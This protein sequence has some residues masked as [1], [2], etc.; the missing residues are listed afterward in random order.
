MTTLGKPVS[1]A[2]GDIWSNALDNARPEDLFSGERLSQWALENG[3]VEKPKPEPL[4]VLVRRWRTD[5]GERKW[6]IVASVETR[7]T[8]L[9][10]H[11]SI[12]LANVTPVAAVDDYDLYCK[13]LAEGEIYEGEIPE[14]LDVSWVTGEA[15]R[16]QLR[17]TGGV[18]KSAKYLRLLE[19]GD[20]AGYGI[21]YAD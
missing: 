14:G 12:I 5:N 19:K 6:A 2:I 13:V 18:I 20:A 11:D 21:E 1:H 10:V 9:Q 15:E 16:G 4:R 3:F 7:S 8:P 17:S